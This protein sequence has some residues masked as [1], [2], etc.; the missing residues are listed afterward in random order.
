MGMADKTVWCETNHM[1]LR[2]CIGIFFVVVLGANFCLSFATG[3]STRPCNMLRF[4]A[5]YQKTLKCATADASKKTRFA[6]KMGTPFEQTRALSSKS[7]SELLSTMEYGPAPEDDGAMH[8]WL[9]AHGRSFGAFINGE[10]R[11]LE[12]RNVHTATAPSTGE[13]LCEV[14]EA[15]ASDADAAVAAARAAHGEW[16]ALS[17][18]ARARHMYSIARHLQKHA[19]LLAVVEAMDNGKTIRETRDADVPLAVR[20]FYHHAGWSQILDREL[21]EWKPL[22]VV[23]QVIPWNFPLLMLAWKIAPALACG[24]TV[25]LKPAPSTRLSAFLFCDILQE[26]GLPKG[27]VNIVT[28][29]NDMGT[30]LVNH[31]D[32]DKVAFTGS[33]GV[34]QFLRKE[35]AGTGK[36]LT[37]E[38]GGKGPIIV[39]DSADIDA[40]VEGVIGGTFFNQGQVC[41]AGTRLLVQENVADEFN[42]RLRARMQTLRVGHSLDKCLDMAALASA[43]RVGAIQQYIDIAHEEGADVYQTPVPDLAADAA[44]GA[45]FAPTII[46]NVGSTSPLVQ[47]E[48]FGP[49][50]TVQTFRTPSEAIALANNSRY[51]LGGSVWTENVGLAL[52]TAISVKAGNLW[53]NAHNL[54]DAA[55]GFGGY[56]ESGY[57]REGGR[58]GLFAY[59]QP[60]HGQGKARLP[61]SK[62]NKFRKN[63]EWGHVEHSMPKVGKLPGSVGIP[64]GDGLPSIDRTPKMYVGGKQARPD[65]QYSVPVLAA[66]GRVMGQVGNGNRKDVRNAVEAAH[67]VSGNW[68]KRSAHD[69]SQILFYIAENL[70]IRRQEFGGLIKDMTGCSE[71]DALGEVDASIS[72]LFYYAAF[73]DKYGG[74][75]QETT[76]YGLTAQINEPIGVIGIACPDEHPLL[77]FVSLVAPAVVRGNSVVALPS[78]KHPLSATT[79]YQVL[80][81]SDLPGGVINILTGNSEHLT[82]NLVTHEDVEAMW[83]FRGDAEGSFHV[84][85][86]SAGNMKRTFTDYGSARNWLDNMAGE[87]EEFLIEASQS[88][89]IWVPMGE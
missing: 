44:G 87:G 77:G 88:K 67:A 25:V 16:A 61:Q 6:A 29:D 9:D 14:Q 74:R 20:H 18:H 1:R 40:A 72:R 65:G 37:L 17:G 66:D 2:Y 73:S 13:A 8:A 15:N 58:E 64:S 41:C 84:E 32:I 54:F 35:T 21:P 85:N 53:I 60:K 23:G 89:S 80:D 83:Y 28:G 47:E 57:G 33:T 12:D 55:T 19:R 22:G 76:L 59:L 39:Y 68:G 38:L 52:E 63:T 56:K 42:R 81:T 3:G 5:S 75:V 86:L 36:K 43:D 49:V 50:A 4:R 45:Y 51:G 7:I 79:L 30:H 27:V 71:E 24:N 82:K 34:G 70:S 46:T 78:E 11:D 69:R 10:W 31:D 48:I 62:T 26:A